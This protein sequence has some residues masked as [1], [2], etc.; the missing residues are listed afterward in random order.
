MFPPAPPPPAAPPAPPPLV[1]P[2]A[3][4]PPVWAPPPPVC[5]PPPPGSRVLSRMYCRPDAVELVPPSNLRRGDCSV[6]PP[7]IG[8]EKELSS[9]RV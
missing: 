5:A 6:L 4:P 1:F 8:A 2:P 3:P 7:N 9:P